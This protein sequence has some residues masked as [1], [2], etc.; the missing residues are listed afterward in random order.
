MLI[1]IDSSHI[2]S[3]K[4]NKLQE[5]TGIAMVATKD[6]NFSKFYC[7]QEIING[8]EHYASETRRKIHAFIREAYSEYLKENNQKPPKNIIIYRQGIAYN[9]L[10]YVENEVYLIKE[11]CEELK[12]HY[13]YVNVNT[14]VSTKF[15][16][17]NNQKTY[18]NKGDYQNPGQGLVILEQVT[19]YKKFEFYIQP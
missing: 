16:E 3:K 17:Y 11:I 13:Y 1:G 7:K 10:E 14:R 12:M 18:N 6:S 9:Q 15:F 4:K 2:W 8:D 19:N 5:R